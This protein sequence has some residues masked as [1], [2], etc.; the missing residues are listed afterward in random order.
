MPTKV[1]SQEGSEQ[2]AP[3]RL[4]VRF[5]GQDSSTTVDSPARHAPQLYRVVR[6]VVSV[7]AGVGVTVD[8]VD[9]RI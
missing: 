5:V 9:H 7:R 2:V 6:V 4:A 3:A 1:P 8:C